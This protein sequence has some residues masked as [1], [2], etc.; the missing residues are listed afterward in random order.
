MPVGMQLAE[1]W[2]KVSGS[3]FNWF[4]TLNIELLNIEPC[5]GFGNLPRDRYE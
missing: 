5:L 1:S 4:R 3:T 2:F